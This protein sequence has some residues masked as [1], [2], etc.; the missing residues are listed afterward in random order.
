MHVKMKC[1]MQ[2]WM[3]LQWVLLNYFMAILILVFQFQL[4]QH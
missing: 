3:L 1:M 4:L 2:L